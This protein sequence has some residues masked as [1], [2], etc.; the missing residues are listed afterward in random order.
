MLTATVAIAITSIVVNVIM[1]VLLYK[2]ESKR[3]EY[4]FIESK[5]EYHGPCARG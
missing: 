1:G 4:N 3:R 5:R 2:G